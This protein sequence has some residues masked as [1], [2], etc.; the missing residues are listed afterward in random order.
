MSRF[1]K[2]LAIKN[3]K[4][5]FSGWV[6]ADVKNAQSVLLTCTLPFRVC[7]GTQTFWK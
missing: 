5:S 7:Q 4:L 2:L 1:L 3:G 6:I